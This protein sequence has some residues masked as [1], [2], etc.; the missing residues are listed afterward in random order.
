MHELSL[1]CY[2]AATPFASEGERLCSM[3]MLSKEHPDAL[4]CYNDLL[5]IGFMK[6]AQSLGF[7]IP[8]DISVAGFDDIPYAQ[9]VSPPLTSVNLQ[10]EGMGE[11][12]MRKMLDLLAGRPAENYTVLDAHLM[13]RG[14]TGNRIR[15]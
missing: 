8:G 9:Y 14:S 10:S 2:S 12:A 15:E 1:R 13:L 4:I 6:E 7:K 5:A 3:I 11:L